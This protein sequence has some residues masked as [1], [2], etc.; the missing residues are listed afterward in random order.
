MVF[1][2]TPAPTPAFLRE[3]MVLSMKVLLPTLAL[4]VVAG[5]LL[6]APDYP[7]RAMR[8]SPTA[9]ASIRNG[10]TTKAQVQALLGP[11]Q[12]VKLQ[13][14]V[15]Q[16]PGV[17]ALPTKYLASEVWGFWSEKEQR[18]SFFSPSAAKSSRYL[19]II[20][21]DGRGVVLDCQSEAS[22]T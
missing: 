18:G 6:V 11:P 17:E 3:V 4:L 13:A 15:Q 5:L 21:F 16:P 22:E 8:L 19:V 2:R 12:S 1:T 10:I 20:Y 14:P 9:V 7:R